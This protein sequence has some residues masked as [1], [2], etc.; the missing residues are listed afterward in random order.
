MRVSSKRLIVKVSSKRIKDDK[1]GP[2]KMITI[3]NQSLSLQQMK[4][5]KKS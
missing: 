5:L 4:K 3:L 1:N 2:K